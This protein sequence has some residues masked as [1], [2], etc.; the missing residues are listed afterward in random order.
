M[1]WQ[2]AAKRI[3]TLNWLILLFLSV[4]SNFLMPPLFTL[5]V[6]LG[7]LIAIANFNMLQYTIRG[8]F[9]MGLDMSIRKKITLVKC[10]FRLVFLAF[11]LYVLLANGWVD[12]IGLVT[13]LSTV[14]ISII[15][16][17]IYSAQK[18]RSMETL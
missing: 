1:D 6:I 7:G 5:G 17:G 18:M 10:Y 16:F 14:V 13:G 15:Y 4:I 11:L 2:N 3:R 12:L 9:S 8:F